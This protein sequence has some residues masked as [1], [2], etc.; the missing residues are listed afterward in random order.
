M[1]AVAS[2]LL[3]S[4]LAGCGGNDSGDAAAD[5][6]ITGITWQWQGSTYNDD[7][8][9]TPDDPALYTITFGD[10]G[11]YQV[12]A[13]CNTVAGTYELDG[14]SITI[15]PGAATLAAC[16]PGSLSSEFLIDLEGAAIATVA[17]GDLLVDIQADVGTMRFSP[18]P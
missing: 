13:D 10:D 12:L 7:T 3:L 6:E 1:L 15:T 18:G 17:D 4:L 8:S 16:P 9:A 2:L 11:T 14:S 5:G